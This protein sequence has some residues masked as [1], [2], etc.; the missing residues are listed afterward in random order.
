MRREIR[1]GRLQR[2]THHRFDVIVKTEGFYQKVPAAAVVAEVGF[3]EF[4]VQEQQLLE[5]LPV[6]HL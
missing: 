3:L 5:I 4:P 1:L 6:G 2:V